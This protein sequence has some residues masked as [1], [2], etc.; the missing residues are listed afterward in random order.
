MARKANSSC[1]QT[2]TTNARQH[3][4]HCRSSTLRSIITPTIPM[5][6]ASN[7]NPILPAGEDGDRFDDTLNRA[8]P[9]AVAQAIE[10]VLDKYSPKQPV[11]HV[12]TAQQRRPPTRDHLSFHRHAA[13]LQAVRDSIA[14]GPPPHIQMYKELP[15]YGLWAMSVRTR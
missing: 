8:E 15:T 14:E 11:C 6:I 9:M 13:P 3:A 12:P 5:E 1:P 2:M 7:F 4:C 10:M